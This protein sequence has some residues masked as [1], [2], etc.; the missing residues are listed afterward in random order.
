MCAV[1]NFFAYGFDVKTGLVTDQYNHDVQGWSSAHQSGPSPVL[2][3]APLT[4]ILE[5]TTGVGLSNIELVILGVWSLRS[6]YFRRVIT[7]DCEIAWL[8]LTGQVVGAGDD[9]VGMNHTKR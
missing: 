9:R 7:I 4:L 5:K 1:I 6:Q 2:L 8:I 3:S